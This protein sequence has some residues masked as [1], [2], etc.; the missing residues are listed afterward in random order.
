MRGSDIAAAVGEDAIIWIFGG[1]SIFRGRDNV[2]LSCFGSDIVFF[3]VNANPLRVAI[4]C[5]ILRTPFLPLSVPDSGPCCSTDSQVS[6]ESHLDSFRFQRTWNSHSLT[7]IHSASF[8]FTVSVSLPFAV[9]DRD[10]PR[11]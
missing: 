3:F 1:I 5:S 6:N 2:F 4:R 10:M 8:R 9:P 7:Q 11:V